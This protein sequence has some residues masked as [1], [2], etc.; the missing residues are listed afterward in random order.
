MK[1]FVFQSQPKHTTTNYFWCLET[2]TKQQQQQEQQDS[3]EQK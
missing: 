1:L 2:G 3:K